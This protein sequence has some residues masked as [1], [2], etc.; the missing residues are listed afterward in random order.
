MSGLSYTF[1]LSIRLFVDVHVD[2]VLRS[3][4]EQI[5]FLLGNDGLCWMRL[6][7]YGFMAFMFQGLITKDDP[8]KCY[9]H[10]P[11]D[12]A[13]LMEIILEEYQDTKL[14]GLNQGRF[15]ITLRDTVHAM[16]NFPI[17]LS[18][19]PLI[20][21]FI[22]GYYPHFQ[23]SQYSSIMAYVASCYETTQSGV[24]KQLIEAK[25]PVHNKKV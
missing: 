5:I 6:N 1:D 13:T 18:D 24:L 12:N 22:K 3:S 10:I 7:L 2:D 17:C 20:E 8:A 11:T 14:Q 4:N 25:F 15:T 23:S 16:D 21:T 19:I 9:D